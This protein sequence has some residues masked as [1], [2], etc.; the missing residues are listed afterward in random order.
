M[1]QRVPS[2]QYPGSDMTA[3]LG[4]AGE[5]N[6]RSEAPAASLSRRIATRNRLDEACF[7]PAV[8]PQNSQTSSIFDL[9]VDIAED[10]SLFASETGV[11]QFDHVPISCRRLRR[12]SKTSWTTSAALAGPTLRWQ[13]APDGPVLPGK[14]PPV[15]APLLF[16]SSAPNADFVDR[17]ST[18]CGMITRSVHIYLSDFIRFALV[19]TGGCHALAEQYGPCPLTMRLP[20]RCGWRPK[21][22]RSGTGGRAVM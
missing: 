6:R 18:G 5:H 14:A 13:Y 22:S 4:R 20:W 8:R 16:P 12:R 7:S 21:V 15:A 2:P 10:P 17:M 19:R 3:K 11:F 1:Q 9:K